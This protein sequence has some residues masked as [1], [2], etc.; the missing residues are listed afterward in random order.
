MIT[1]NKQK[2]QEIYNSTGIRNI[3]HNTELCKWIDENCNPELLHLECNSRNLLHLKIFTI[4]NPEQQVKCTN[5]LWLSWCNSKKKVVCVNSCTCWKIP[6]IE[7][8]KASLLSKYGVD[9]ISKRPATN[10]KRKSNNLIKYGVESNLQTQECKE[11]I[12]QTCLEK[13]GTT[14]TA[15][16][17]KIIEK[18]KQTC[19]EK[20]GVE[21]AVASKKI[22]NKIEKTCLEKYGV[23]STLMTNEFKENRKQDYMEKYGVQFVGQVKEYREKQ[24]KTCLE[25]YGNRS[26]LGNDVIKQK[27]ISTNLEKYGV[28]NPAS[29]PEIKEKI[30]RT[31]SIK[32]NNG[33]YTK[34]HISEKSYKILENKEDFS[35]LL[36][37]HGAITLSKML[38]VGNTL[39]YN[40]HKKHEL[41]ILNT[42]TS[43]GEKQLGNW[44][45]TLGVNYILND[46]N[47]CSPRELD[48]YLPDHNLAIEYNGLYWHSDAQ[49]ENKY[50]HQE[51]TE[52]CRKNGIQLI[53]IFEDEWQ[54][55]QDIC[56]SIILQ[57]LGLSKNKVAARKC[58]LE[59]I[60]NKDIQPFMNE[61][62]L[63]GHSTGQ[64]NIVLKYDNEI[65]MAMTF[66]TPRYNKSFDY[67]LLRLATKKNYTVIGGTEKLWKYFLKNFS[68]SSVISYCDLRWFSGKVYSKLNFVNNTKKI[69]PT[70][71]Y[72][73]CQNR[74]HR[75]KFTK[76]KAVKYA[77]K[78]STIN[79]NVLNQLTERHIT[80]EILGLYRIWDCGQAVW[81]W[82]G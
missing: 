37:M 6:Q 42:L 67:E 69:L 82:N 62:H 34:S 65:I 29:S 5:G 53:Q 50:Y 31:Q 49:N 79:E 1:Y 40:Y 36:S 26:C 64:C 9:H 46:R 4:F 45:A 3:I 59:I 47:I 72:T 41:N 54:N 81:K 21:Y 80:K 35:E 8:L 7:N 51:K 20:Y 22:R 30:R 10:E 17:P 57:Y 76:S 56:K 16:V 71:W 33:W 78:D 38:G 12:H 66:R 15:T 73:D 52:H 44:I 19:M 24:E 68:P 77:I 61:N 27:I 32:F 39:I 58:K 14:C 60:S 25:K 13:Y 23:K 2:L 43:C 28:N 63:Q 70:Y 18:R 55:N 48:I 75:S 11:K 74:F